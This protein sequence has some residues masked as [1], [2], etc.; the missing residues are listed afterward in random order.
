MK[1]LN[2][3]VGG[4][5]L[6]ATLSASAC[7]HAQSAP[8]VCSPAEEAV[9]TSLV[10]DHDDPNPEGATYSC[11]SACPQGQHR[12]LVEQDGAPE[13]KLFVFNGK[14]QRAVRYAC[15]VP[16]ASVPASELQPRPPPASKPDPRP[17]FDGCVKSCCEQSIHICG[18]SCDADSAV[19]GGCGDM[20]DMARKCQAGLCND[21]FDDIAA[22]LTSHCH[23]GLH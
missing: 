11:E 18:R 16:V 22:T 5:L 1:V 10:Y 20:C 15:Q 7:V 12:V 9:K 17:C 13:L 19:R 21:C 4:V 8:P 3:L 14:R 23:G 2:S 6:T